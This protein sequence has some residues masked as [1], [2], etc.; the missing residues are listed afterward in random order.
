MAARVGML[1]VTTATVAALASGASA[2]RGA[3]ACTTK[4]RLVGT[5]VVYCGSA[6]AKLSS[7]AGVMFRNGYCSRSIAD[8]IQ[9]FTVKLG[10]RTQKAA[11]NSGK[12]YFGLSV[13][14]PFSH[15]TGGSVIAYAN[16]RQW[17]GSEVSFSGDDHHGTFA[18]QGING[19]KGT[20]S[21]SY[22]C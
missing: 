20:A 8:G 2:A 11:M 19:S 15:P 1:L 17:G 13:R 22:R 9:Q 6:T 16:G 7:F 12:Q 18:A 4:A 21:G 5:T 10:Q 3:A 14:G